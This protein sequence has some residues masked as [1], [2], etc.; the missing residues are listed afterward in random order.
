M[1]EKIRQDIFKRAKQWIHEA[2][3]HIRDV[4]DEPLYI[5]TKSNPND[6]VTDMDRNTEKYF[7]EKIQQTYPDH[8]VLGEEGYGDDIQSLEGTVWI[9]DPIDGTMNFVHQKRNFA[10]SIGIFHEG[11]G[12]IGLIYNVM[13]DQLYTA[14]RGQGAFKNE[15]KLPQLANKVLGESILVINSVWACPNKKINHEGVQTL[16]KRV[17]GTRSYGSAA[18]E[19]AFI[20]EGIVDGYLTLQ[21]SPWDFAAGIVLIEEVGGIITQANGEKLNLLSNNTVLCSNREINDLIKDNI[22]LL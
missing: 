21:L 10:I 4:I 14:I 13:E 9:I 5:D 22:E 20:A 17:R 11:I 2:G 19:F 7:L 16:I 3:K 12:E 8:R 1:D 15:K 6:L 18:L